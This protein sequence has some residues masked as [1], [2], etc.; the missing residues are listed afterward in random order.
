MSEEE[1]L[2]YLAAQPKILQEKQKK[3][4]GFLQKYYHRGA[5]FQT[6]AEWKGEAAPLAGLAAEM[7]FSAPTGADRVDKSKLPEVL[8]VKD[9][10]K[11]GK[12]KW[13]HLAA[14]DTTDKDA[15]WAQDPTM[16]RKAERR[17]A[18]TEQVF[19]KPKN[20]KT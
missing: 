5:F 12:S 9:F 19:T 15:L 20:T 18:G 4:Y 3:N 10:G 8:Q 11:R 14:E 16:R 17:L 6:E 2:A 1:K 13:T 7:D